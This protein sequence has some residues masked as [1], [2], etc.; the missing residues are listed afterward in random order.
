MKRL[1]LVA[2]LA[3]GMVFATSNQAQGQSAL[4]LQAGYSW[5]EG[6]IAAGYQYSDFEAKLGYMFT[7]MPGDGSSVSGPT[8]T[9]IWGPKWYESG[10]YLSYTYN[11]VGYRAQYSTNG[12]SWGDNN[13]EGMNILSIGYKIGG[14]KVYLKADVGYGWSDSAN[15]MSYGIVVGVPLFGTY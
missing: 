12:G 5:S 15:G 9:L 6:V 2:M 4:N 10:Y 3:I 14:E 1:F 13:I 8:F 7:S 11:S